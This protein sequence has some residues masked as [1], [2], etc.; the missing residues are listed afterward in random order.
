[1][2]HYVALALALALLVE[3]KLVEMHGPDGQQIF[4]N[5]NE[6]TSLRQ[7]LASSR[8]HFAQGVRCQVFLSN[9][10]FVTTQETC[11]EV[12]DSLQR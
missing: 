1:M 4:I 3:L 12:R 6:I 7:P 8:E 10:N 9:G 2:G 5:A 11:R